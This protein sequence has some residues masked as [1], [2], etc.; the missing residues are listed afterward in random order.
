MALTEILKGSD[1]VIQITITDGTDPIDL[2]TADDITVSVY[3]RADVIIQQ[4][5]LS[6]S[7]VII[8]DAS[9]GICTV[10]LDRD[11]TENLE[12]KRLYIQVDLQ[13]VNAGFED[14]VMIEK[15]IKPL[16]DLL[17]SVS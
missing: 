1:E 16:C 11:N 6:D 9:N 14:G 5:K 17:N 2:A 10:N 4:W 8:T 15:D 3:Q 12:S 13:L 7:E